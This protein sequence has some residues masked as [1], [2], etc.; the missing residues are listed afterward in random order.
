[1]RITFQQNAV[2]SD[3]YKNRLQQWTDYFT[4]SAYASTYAAQEDGD[5]VISEEKSVTFECRWCP[6][7]DVVTSTGFRVLFHGDHY[8]ILSV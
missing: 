5:E 8:N 2:Y 4:C 6:E 1:M 7:L 3:K